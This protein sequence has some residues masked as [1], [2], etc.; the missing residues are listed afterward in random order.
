MLPTYS[1]NVILAK[2]RAMYGRRLTPEHYRDLLACRTVGEIAAYLKNQTDY[3]SILAGVN[4]NDIHCGQLEVK[5][6][7]KLFEDS[8]ALC[9]Y[10][11]TIGE[12][13]AKYLISRSEIEQ[14]MTD[15][16]HLGLFRTF[17]KQ[18]EK[19]QD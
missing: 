1:S 14:I 5:L 19:R 2:A 12:H 18:M 15:N 7:Q 6:R 16:M 4:K 9:R 11:V 17:K 8:S 3:G 13:F 10:E